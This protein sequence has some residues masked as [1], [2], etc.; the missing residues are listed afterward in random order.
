MPDEAIS[1][2]ALIAAGAALIA[3]GIPDNILGIWLAAPNN[4]LAILTGFPA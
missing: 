2:R 3:D 4:P 1:G